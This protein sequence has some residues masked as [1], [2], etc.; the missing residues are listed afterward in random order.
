MMKLVRSLILLLTLFTFVSTANA[1]E[2]PDAPPTPDGTLRRIR[3]PVLMYHYVEPLPPN[4]DDIRRGLTI[5]PELFRDHLAYLQQQGYQTVS[6]AQ[7]YDALMTGSPL[8]PKPIILTFDDGYDNHYHI[9]FPLLQEFGMIGTFYVITAAL[10]NQRSG[11]ITW[12]QAAQMAQAGMEIGAH[13]KNHVELRGRSYDV[14]VYEVIGSIESV[15][16]HIG[17][18]PITFSYPVGRYDRD[19]LALMASLQP[20]MAVTTRSGMWISTDQMLEIP[21]I[22]ISPNTSAFALS[23]LLSQ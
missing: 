11:Y 1:V 9:V 12:E 20:M 10:D 22:R 4:A 17:Q 18:R 3:L 6:F 21:R 7:V 14:L 8:P 5:S 23:R 16:A 19:T 13:T 2:P 15:T